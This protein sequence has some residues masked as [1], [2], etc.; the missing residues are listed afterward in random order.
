[1]ILA[2]LAALYRSVDPQAWF[3][4]AAGRSILQHGLPAHEIWVLGA[5]GQPSWLPSWLF[6]VALRLTRQLGGDLGVALW[7]AGWA[8][9]AMA[10]AIA[11]LRAVGAASWSAVLLAP[12]VLATGRPWFEPRPDAVA[13]VLLLLAVLC[14]ESARVGR[15]RTRW[16]IPVQAAWANIHAGWVAGP[17]VVSL[18]ALAESI[19]ALGSR[20]RAAP[21]ATSPAPGSGSWARAARWAT[22]GVVLL[23]ASALVPSPLLQLSRPLRFLGDGLRDPVTGSV[24]LRPWTFE[25]EKLEPFNLL[26]ML[27]LVAVVVGARRMWRASPGLT[28]VAGALLTLT[29]CGFRL[30][31]LTAWAAFAP[32]ALAFT[33][34]SRAWLERLRR[35][36]AVL[37]AFAGGAALAFTPGFA[38]GIHPDLTT[39]PVR[40]TALADSAGFD[41]PVLNSLSAGGYLLWARGDRHPPLVDARG[42]GS[43]DLRRLFAHADSDPGAL[44]SL[45]EAWGFTHAILRPPIG[46]RDRLALNMSR[47]I[48]WALVYFDD[49]GLLFVRYSHAPE[50]AYARAYRY[51][52]PDELQMLDMIERIP[53]DPGLGQRLELELERA[54]RESPLHGRASYWLGFL[55]QDRHDAPAAAHYY[56][57]A[58]ALTPDMPGLA[59]RMGMVYESLDEREKAIRALRRA[60]KDP[61]DR[62]IA[63]SMLQSLEHQK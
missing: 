39:V 6:D 10:L 29:L 27:S 26:F 35:V 17:G 12:L 30:R 50:L 13:V 55:A 14:L 49:A 37:A 47:R 20:R 9:A 41:G 8:A 62:A 21:D 48:E 16:L 54:R 11:L 56:E 5:R 52:T 32:L 3:H 1:V 59:L 34:T 36:P 61:S 38:P 60:A 63:R 23:G 19:G 43:L 2:A 25:G 18:Y 28:L 51:Y 40:A 46:E 31:E 57:E 22:L 58:I 4:L 24:D 33:P 15:D 7:R 44:D 45:Q 42:L 53:R